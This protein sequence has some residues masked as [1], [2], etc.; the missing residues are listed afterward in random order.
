MRLQVFSREAV[1]VYTTIGKGKPLPAEAALRDPPRAPE[2]HLAVEDQ[3][4]PAVTLKDQPPQTPSGNAAE[5]SALSFV[6]L[7]EVVVG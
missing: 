2:S 4:R 6:M 1:D 3:P 7:L 5:G